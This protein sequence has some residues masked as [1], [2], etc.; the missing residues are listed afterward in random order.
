MTTYLENGKT[1]DCRDCG[2]DTIDE[3]YMVHDSVWLASGLSK[4]G[5]LLCI[6]CLERRIGRQ[7]TSDDFRDCPANWVGMWGEKSERL[8]QRLGGAHV[9]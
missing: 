9:A 7:L 4:R 3:F 5:G 1:F 2:Y 6:G 8:L